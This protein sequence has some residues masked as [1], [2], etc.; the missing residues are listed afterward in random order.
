MIQY[1]IIAAVAF[2]TAVGTGFLSEA[3]LD[4][5]GALSLPAWTP[6]NKVF[7]IIWLAIFLLITASAMIIWTLKLKDKEICRRNIASIIFLL[8]AILIF[9]W[10]FLFFGMHLLNAAFIESIVLEIAIAALIYLL[11]PLSRMATIILIPYFL[12]VAFATFLNYTVM[13][14]N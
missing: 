7:G 9:L 10:E 4:W 12:W 14:M 3:N 1:F 6:P 2:V 5:Y 11:W 13:I 8:N